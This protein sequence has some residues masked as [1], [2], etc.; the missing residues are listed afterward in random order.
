MRVVSDSQEFPAFLWE[1]GEQIDLRVLGGSFQAELRPVALHMKL[2][3]A[4]DDS[5]SFCFVL[6]GP[7]GTTFVAQISQRMLRNALSALEDRR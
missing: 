7:E 6:L 4:I 5:P 2:D 3:G 1:K